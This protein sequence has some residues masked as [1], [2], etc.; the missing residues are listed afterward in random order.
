MRSF[1]FKSNNTRKISV[2]LNPTRTEEYT[3]S[4]D[5]P[6]D[7]L[8]KE[9]ATRHNLGSSVSSSSSLIKAPTT[10][11]CELH[12][13]NFKSRKVVWGTLVKNLLK[14]QYQ[15]TL[16]PPFYLNNSSE[17]PSSSQ[18]S[19]TSPGRSGSVA[20]VNKTS[21][22]NSYSSSNSSNNAGAVPINANLSNILLA[23]NEQQQQQSTSTSSSTAKNVSDSVDQL[24]DE[25]TL[26]PKKKEGTS[27]STVSTT[28]TTTTENNSSLVVPSPIQTSTTEKPKVGLHLLLNKL[29]NK[30]TT[31]TAPST[32][33]PATARGMSIMRISTSSPILF[34][35][36]LENHFPNGT[37]ISVSSIPPI[38]EKMLSYLKQDRI[39][40]T[41]GIFRLTGS[42][43]E[44]ER[45]IQM[46]NE[47][48]SKGGDLT[49]VVFPN[50]IDPNVVCNLLVEY[51]N[52]LDRA[53]FEPFHRFVEINEM[54]NDAE[55]VAALKKVIDEMHPIYRNVIRDFFYFLVQILLYKEENRLSVK[56]LSVVLGPALLRGKLKDDDEAAKAVDINNSKKNAPVNATI[57][58]S[59]RQLSQKMV[60]FYIHTVGQVI[61]SYN[62]I[63]DEEELTDLHKLHHKKPKKSDSSSSS[64]TNKTLDAFIQ[65][66][67][68]HK[69][70]AGN[71]MS[72]VK[73]HGESTTSTTDILSSTPREPKKPTTKNDEEWENIQ[74]SWM[75]FVESWKKK[76]SDEQKAHEETAENIKITKQE[77]EF[78]RKQMKEELNK[79]R[80][81]LDEKKRFIQQKRSE[82]E[83]QKEQIQLNWENEKVDLEKEKTLRSKE[84]QE[85]REQF[86]QTLE[87][88]NIK[89]FQI[90]SIMGDEDDDAVTRAVI[91]AQAENTSGDSSATGE[92]LTT[93]PATT[94]RSASR[95]VIGQKISVDSRFK[96]KL[97]DASSSDQKKN[98]K[99]H[100]DDEDSEDSEDSEDDTATTNTTTTTTAGK[101][102][103]N[104]LFTDLEDKTPQSSFGASPSKNIFLPKDKTNA[105]SEEDDDDPAHTKRCAACKK[106][107]TGEYM[108]TSDGYYHKPCFT[109]C[110]C[111]K[112]IVGPFATVAGKFWC[113]TCIQN[114]NKHVKY[115]TKDENAEKKSKPAAASSGDLECSAC[116]EKIVNKADMVKALG[117]CF[118][119]QCFLCQRCGNEFENM[120]FYDLMGDP[121]CANCKRKS[122]KS[123]VVK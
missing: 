49:P 72:A 59:T 11:N 27:S 3:L 102:S 73:R 53:L 109:C 88:Y 41:P 103:S 100:G 68:E 8:L 76:Y 77:I 23:A 56:S 90:D 111:S 25:I 92:T 117:K 36:L 31:N 37:S 15:V 32:L 57:L 21:P 33:D 118:H 19:L 29:A 106:K 64:N 39:Q 80:D 65:K 97:S 17:T 85:I 119:K 43:V 38:L 48:Q 107:I 96:K 4:L 58:I 62:S 9:I 79:M 71:S 87:Y 6:I 91:N 86:K 78:E 16:E 22:G 46:L 81:Q 104:A 12:V 108:E 5:Q 20:A 89:D 123:K 34:G 13:T 54:T 110:N 52:K 114:K 7:D 122:I 45:F 63:F 74:K 14:E 24:V 2:Q 121:V 61:E 94:N 93:S 69:Q 60:E 18:T 50:S 115:Q 66:L 40:R 67:Q 120:K 70:R 35:G 75:Q 99:Q 55:R 28:T 47:A 82:W 84:I 42:A 101:R 83:L 98:H 116:K 105:S 1:S 51:F 30:E 26:S 44:K 112:E 113:A 10:Q 95:S